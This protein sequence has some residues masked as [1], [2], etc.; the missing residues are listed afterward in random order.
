M[1]EKCLFAATE[2]SSEEVLNTTTVNHAVKQMGTLRVNRLIIT[3]HNGIALYDS[4]S[5]PQ[6][7]S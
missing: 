4:S 5:E 2:V 6:T 3:D 7:G 1:I